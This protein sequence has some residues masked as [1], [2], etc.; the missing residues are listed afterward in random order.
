VEHYVQA[1]IDPQQALALECTAKLLQDAK[2]LPE[3]LYGSNTGVY[4]GA[5][6]SEFSGD[7]KS[8][9]FV[10]GTNVSMIPA[11]ISSHYN[12]TGPSKVVNTA[13]ASSLEAI[14]DAFKD[15]QSGRI[16]YAIAGGVN[17]LYA[18]EFTSCL[19][20]A[21]FL[22][23]GGRCRTFDEAADGYT[24]AEG[25][26]LMLLT[27]ETNVE[28]YYSRVL[29][30][31]SNHNGY[32]PVI[33]APSTSA[34]E[35]LI[36]GACEWSGVD[37]AAIDYVECHGTGTKLGDP[38]EVDAL[39]NIIGQASGRSRPCYISSIKSNIGH[40]ESAA[41]AAGLLNAVLTLHHQSVPVMPHFK[42]LNQNLRLGTG[43][44][45]ASSNVIVEAK[46]AGVSGFGCSGS[47]THLLI[48]AAEG[49]KVKK[50]RS[51]PSMFDVPNSHVYDR[52]AN[53]LAPPIVAHGAAHI[54]QHLPIAPTAVEVGGD[55]VTLPHANS[56]GTRNIDHNPDAA[57]TARF[58]KL[59]ESI[60]IEPVDLPAVVSESGFDSLSM[61]EL[62]LRIEQDFSVAI[63]YAH[64]STCYQ[65]PK[66]MQNITQSVALT[67]LWSKG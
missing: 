3:D 44:K 30:G 67:R 49:A 28:T 10:T 14:F 31:N 58:V 29:G 42:T 23:P 55:Q 25:C 13:C 51:L 45:V 39:Q 65:Y 12:L 2:L 6:N 35:A 36:K 47:N 19:Q 62:L 4:I 21:G 20:Q 24:R 57:F 34:Q 41:G 8:A 48:Q 32:S 59:V 66:H 15:I 64:V 33:T 60:I 5:W 52:L 43:L 17:L 37:P 1:G 46:I 54:T 63:E 26:V 16:E 56:P 50:L 11:R 40:L 18:P 38:I 22:A 27:K 7:T 61:T 53:S 9:Y